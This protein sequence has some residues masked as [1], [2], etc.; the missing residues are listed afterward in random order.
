MTITGEFESLIALAG[1]ALAVLSTAG[2]PAYVFEDVLGLRE[3][4]AYGLGSIVFGGATLFVYS[5][6]MWDILSA[7]ALFQL[8]GLRIDRPLLWAGIALTALYGLGS[9]G[10]WMEEREDR[11]PKTG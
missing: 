7:H 3:S 5:Q 4:V 6:P 9:I 2:L 1:L 10:F 8:T 11:A